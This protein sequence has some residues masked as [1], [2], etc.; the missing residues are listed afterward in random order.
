MKKSKFLKKS[1]AML[2]AVMLVV[3]M[4][5]LSAAAASPNF[6]AAYAAATGETQGR[7][8]QE[9]NTLT[10][11]YRRGAASV[12]L[13]VIVGEG[14]LVYY[15]D[16][17]TAAT[18]DKQEPVNGN[19]AEIKGLDTKLYANADGNVE[20]QFSVA[21]ASAAS[22]RDNYTVVLK[23][24]DAN[25]ETEITDF[26]LN[27]V[28]GSEIPNWEEASIGVDFVSVTMPYD[29]VNSGVTYQIRNMSVSE[30]ATWTITD[31]AGTTTR[32]SGDDTGIVNGSPEVTVQD[33]DVITISNGG[34]QQRYTLHINI[35]DGFTSFD[36]AEGLDA[37]MFTDSGDIVVLLPFG[38]AEDAEGAEIDVTPIF[39]LDYP[40]AT[41]YWGDKEINGVDDTITL[42]SDIIVDG[43]LLSSADE[44]PG[45]GNTYHCYQ[46]N[47]ADDWAWRVE[48]YK[49][50]VDF[51]AN[52]DN[53]SSINGV[54]YAK[55][56]NY[57]EQL[58]IVY[59]DESERT[60]NVYF[61]ET[62]VNNEAAIES[63]VIGSEQATIDEEN[64]TIDITLPNG[65]DLSNLVLNS[66][67]TTMTMTASY[68]AEIEFVQVGGNTSL[69][70]AGGR[71]ATQTF[72]STATIDAREP[73]SVVVRSQ[74]YDNH[75]ETE[76]FYTLN[77]NAS[78][79]YATAE[80]TSFTIS[81]GDYDFTASVENGGIDK[82]GNV[83]LKVPYAIYDRTLLDDGF[84]KFYYTKGIGTLATV[85]GTALPL[86]G[87]A[88]TP[89]ATYLPQ[90]G[91]KSVG[92]PIAVRMVGE[93][94]TQNSQQYRITIERQD[95]QTASTLEKFTLVGDETMEVPGVSH[96]Y[97][98]TV[99]NSTVATN[100]EGAIEAN[101]SWTAGQYWGADQMEV[102]A[103]VA[104]KSNARVFYQNSYGDYME[105][106]NSGNGE[107]PDTTVN[108]TDISTVFEVNRNT[109]YNN[110]I[111]YVLSEQA[112][113]NLLEAGKMAEH[114]ITGVWYFD[115]TD[116]GGVELPGLLNGNNT[117]NYTRYTL[118]MG[119]NSAEEGAALQTMTLVDGTGWEA[120]L[121]IDVR[122]NSLENLTVPYALTSDLDEDGDL[123]PNDVNTSV[124]PIF[125]TY[126]FD[127]ANRAYVLGSDVNIDAGKAVN[128]LDDPANVPTAGV[129]TT[130][131]AVAKGNAVF[132]DM[133]AYTGEWTEDKYE[134][135]VAEGKPFLLI[136]REGDMYV[137]NWQDADNDKVVEISEFERNTHVEANSL[138]ISSENGNANTVQVF[139]VKMVP[140]EPNA[141]TDFASFYFTGYERFPATVD[142][143]NH[144]ISVV[145]PFGT[146]YT[147]LIPNFELTADSQ[148]AIITVDDP[149][150][151]GKP[152][153][154]GVTNV[155]FTSTRKF[156][157]I[158]EN[159]TTRAE[160][161]VNVSVADE[162]SDVTPDDWFYN[163]VMAAAGFGYVNGMG[164]G[165]YEPYGTT[166][167]AQF[168]K[169]LAE[170]LGYD[171]TAYT[172]TAF[173]DVS[174]DHWAMAAIAF[175]ADQEIILGYETGNFEPSK[176]ITRQEA[177]L[178]LQRAFD[179][180]G[181]ESTQYPDD[182]SIAGW[183]ED[184]V[185]AVKHAGLMKGDADTGNFRPT[186][187]LNRAEMAT[188]LMNAHRAGLI[189]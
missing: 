154:K 49:E 156:T 50:F 93:D 8:D 180:V 124:N 143:A 62:Q 98:G 174:E 140:A 76:E 67:T 48:N 22:V 13:T 129:T 54:K 27:R 85:N 51:T 14:N 60:Y 80:I 148:G 39:D 83:T 189:K 20:I 97:Q 115:T 169:I 108:K 37:A 177:A 159:E 70:P 171:E 82:N 125:L 43:T 185:Y 176:T 142:A 17:S 178:M 112:W 116:N 9:G 29:S 99:D 18:T 16:K 168:A 147:Y 2:L 119:A 46:G 127:D 33:E 163:D 141:G 65:T 101:V 136:S 68:G 123:N 72:T 172:T 153:R 107:L 170:A 41:A 146:E 95:P 57:G 47:T 111:L 73:I 66:A 25:T 81:N 118:N 135:Y 164:N 120:D 102:I 130:N 32:G 105:L 161:T 139:D 74:D 128:T 173:P 31:A 88:I 155:N 182:A 58:T 34:R 69:T 181:T 38:T 3:A 126:D 35:A 26:E 186:S 110:N 52:V 94:L 61:C 158:A 166:T 133:A 183:A 179:L 11:S 187:T 4:I 103:E 84:W 89:A 12:D 167:R 19:K 1:L 162:F 10:G 121:E 109:L 45:W 157:V 96:E 100:H 30:G 131:P 15:T 77:V 134:D 122:T 5:P 36:T 117:G 113:V 144:T 40:G 87:S 150:L 114:P 75:T 59:A 184:G 21:D 86:T 175:C 91:D 92:D 145:L 7:L 106:M 64:K 152:V 151:L 44:G 79:D 132:Y 137:Y 188:I 56:N 6:Q 42:D 28:L 149:D 53:N 78:S 71:S 160:W 165:K 63:L 90:V 104:A 24:V 138:T 55:Q 23:P